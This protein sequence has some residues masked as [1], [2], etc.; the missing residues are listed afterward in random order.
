MFCKPT[1]LITILGVTRSALVGVLENLHTRP[2]W[3]MRYKVRSYQTWRSITFYINGRLKS[4][5]KVRDNDCE[6]FHAKSQGK[7]HAVQSSRKLLKLAKQVL[8]TT[9]PFV[10]SHIMSLEVKFPFT[11]RFWCLNKVQITHHGITSEEEFEFGTAVYPLI[12]RTAKRNQIIRK[13]I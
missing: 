1:R 12:Y 2:G 8:I 11:G 10:Y 5:E 7:A 3:M 13:F 6:L 4:L 9:K